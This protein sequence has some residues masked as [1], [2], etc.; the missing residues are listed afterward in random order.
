MNKVP[1]SVVAWVVIVLSV[2][3]VGFGFFGKS[4]YQG[5]TY[6]LTIPR[7]HTKAI[8]TGGGKEWYALDIPGYRGG[9]PE[10]LCE[11]N[12]GSPKLRV[13]LVT[14]PLAGLYR[15]YEF[16]GETPLDTLFRQ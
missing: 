12:I 8:L 16:D 14:K 5:T 10:F 3:S 4:V 1:A 15:A 9:R 2:V 13:N 6:T 11:L 7:D